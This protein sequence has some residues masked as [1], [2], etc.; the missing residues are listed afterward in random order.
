MRQVD[1]FDALICLE[2]QSG[3]LRK[4]VNQFDEFRHCVSD[5]VVS[6]IF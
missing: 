6:N 5:W 4:T 1:T 3:I 2:W